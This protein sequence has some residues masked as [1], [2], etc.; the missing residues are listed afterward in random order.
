VPLAILGDGAIDQPSQARGLV[1]GVIWDKFEPRSVSQTE[2]PAHLAT[3]EST[4]ARK[5]DLH[6]LHGIP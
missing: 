5:S 3:Q 2:A 4:C 6:L 1:R